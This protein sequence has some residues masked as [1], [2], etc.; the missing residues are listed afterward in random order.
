MTIQRAGLPLPLETQDSIVR[1]P[2]ELVE[3]RGGALHG[4]DAR[5]PVG[6][7]EGRALG[8]VIGGRGDHVHAHLPEGEHRARH[9]EG[10]GDQDAAL[11][12]NTGEG[13]PLNPEKHVPLSV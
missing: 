2:H 11:A 5:Q 1:N 10:A 4:G 8:P 7:R 12:V 6:P 3:G 13:F 9:V